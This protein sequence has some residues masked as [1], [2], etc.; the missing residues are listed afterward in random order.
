[1]HEEVQVRKIE[2][3][4]KSRHAERHDS[5]K[6][7]TLKISVIEPRAIKATLQKEAA[8]LHMKTKLTNKQ[9]ERCSD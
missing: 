8:I 9:Q 6:Y 7:I 5:E 3:R 4:R 2:A 1:M